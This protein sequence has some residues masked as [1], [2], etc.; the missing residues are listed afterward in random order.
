MNKQNKR[1]FTLIELLVVVLIIGILAAVALPQYNKAVAKARLAEHVQFVRDLQQAIDLYVLE[2]GIVNVDF[3]THPELLSVD[4]S[5]ARN[6][7][8]GGENW[9]YCGIR[10]VSLTADEEAYCE[11]RIAAINRDTP[12]LNA[13]RVANSGWTNSCSADPTVPLLKQLCDSLKPFGWE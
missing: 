6:K 13:S 8:C 12:D 3:T 1:A 9:S 10:C 11:V 4:L 2:N 5:A 7:L